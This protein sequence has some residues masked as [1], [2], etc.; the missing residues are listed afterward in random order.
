MSALDTDKSD[1]TN[2]SETLDKRV[3]LSYEDTFFIDCE[4][5]R[6]LLEESVRIKREMDAFE[7]IIIQAGTNVVLDYLSKASGFKRV[8]KAGVKAIICDK[9]NMG[10]YFFPMIWK[11]LISCRKITC[12]TSDGCVDVV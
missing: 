7:K 3:P 6:K 9:F 5:Y 2:V 8:T 10:E 11:S 1:E 4:S 12:N